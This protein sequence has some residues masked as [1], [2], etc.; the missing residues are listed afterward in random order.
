MIGKP[1]CEHAG[2]DL[3]TARNPARYSSGIVP[4]KPVDLAKHFADRKRARSR[5]ERDGLY[6]PELVG[7]RGFE[8][9][10]LFLCMKNVARNARRESPIYGTYLTTDANDIPADAA[11][12]RNDAPRNCLCTMVDCRN[13]S[14][15]TRCLF[16]ARCA[17]SRMIW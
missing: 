7:L 10:G 13:H 17:A 15:F 2:I 5:R 6:R 16:P 11:I 8:R 9:I 1:R 14:E 3:L 12:S 4:E